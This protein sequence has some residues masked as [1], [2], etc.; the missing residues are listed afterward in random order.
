MYVCVCVETNTR[1]KSKRSLRCWSRR[2]IGS[3]SGSRALF[4]LRR[5]DDDD[6]T[7]AYLNTRREM[8]K[9][10]RGEA[11]EGVDDDDDDDDDDVD[12]DVDIDEDEPQTTITNSS[13]DLVKV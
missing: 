10:T 8:K 1:D 11:G 2:E 4:K 9:E 12:N 6:Y 5:C 7:R 3:K 13:P